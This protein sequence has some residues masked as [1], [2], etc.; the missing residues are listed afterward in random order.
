M[1]QINYGAFAVEALKITIFCL[2]ITGFFKLLSVSNNT[3]LIVFDM[4]VMSSAATFSVEHK[5]LDHIVLGSSVVITSI[6]AGGI[7]GYYNPELA[8][9]LTIIYAGLAFYLPRSTAK[10]NIFVTG[11]VMFLIFTALPFSLQNGLRYALD[12]FLVI[13]VFI[14]FHYILNHKKSDKNKEKFN[15]TTQNQLNRITAIMAVLSLT[16]AWIIS[17]ILSRSYQLSHLYWIGLTALVIIQASQQKTIL[18]AIKR[19]LVNA[20]GAIIIV[21]LFAYIIPPDFWVNFSLLT[22]FLFL[23]FFLGFTYVGRTLF[24]E[25]FVLGFTHLF[26]H[27]Q[28]IIAWDRV[29]LT[30]IGGTIVI[31]ATPISYWLVKKT[32]K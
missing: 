3:L 11:S 9:L 23:I 32:R 10:T 16:A 24:I 28:N 25:L 15:I 21:L 14:G 8:K 26:G 5:C 22:L 31:V 19:I 17:N 20:L 29:I 13:A 6:I 18:T 27:Y 12:G 2:L 1:N 4:A 30:L 7:I